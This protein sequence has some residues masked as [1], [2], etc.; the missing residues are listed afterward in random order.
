MYF[1]KKHRTM[2]GM[3]SVTC[4]HGVIGAPISY[5]CNGDCWEA[6]GTSARFIEQY[7]KG[8]KAVGRFGNSMP[9]DSQDFG[10]CVDILN[11]HPEWK[12]RMCEMKRLNGHKDWAR[13]ARSWDMFTMIYNDLPHDKPYKLYTD[14]D[15]QKFSYFGHLLRGISTKN[16]LLLTHKLKCNSDIFNFRLKEYLVVGSL[17]LQDVNQDDEFDLYTSFVIDLF[18]ENMY[19]QSFRTNGA[20]SGSHRAESYLPAIPKEEPEPI[21]E[22]APVETMVDLE[23]KVVEIIDEEIKSEVPKD[24]PKCTIHYPRKPVLD[25]PVFRSQEIIKKLHEKMNVYIKR[26][27]STWQSTSYH[28]CPHYVLYANGE[29]PE[30]THEESFNM[31]MADVY[32]LNE[33][34]NCWRLGTCVISITDQHKLHPSNKINDEFE[35][36]FNDEKWVISQSPIKL[37]TYYDEGLINCG[38]D[39][40]QEVITDEEISKIIER[41]IAEN[42]KLEKQE[43]QVN[44]NSNRNPVQNFG[45]VGIMLG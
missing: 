36:I 22:P 34:P 31:Y 12:E 17:V 18:P 13:L 8:L 37:Y 9:I 26:D 33:T 4:Q 42:I 29:T 11:L 15:R 6:R 45:F 2:I 23:N 41:N 35:V 3:N 10:R 38:G 32:P 7:M 40:E 21:I 16:G 19:C 25:T 24:P 5:W 39:E 14:R 1:D 43:R 27:P 44:D 20:S 30:N 28:Y